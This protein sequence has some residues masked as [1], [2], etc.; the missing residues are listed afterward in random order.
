[1]DGA[2]KII[3]KIIED[4]R[5][6]AAYNIE[7][8][9]KEAEGIIKAA[10]QDV[11]QKQKIIH[12]RTQKEVAEKRKRL[13][14]AAELDARKIRLQAKQELISEV[15]AL[16]SNKVNSL[17]QEEYR[18]TLS[19]MII[20]LSP[21]GDEEIIVS[22]KDKQK[23]GHE[24]IKTVNVKLE[25]IKINGEI[26][27]SA[28]NREFGGGFILKSGNIESNNSFNSIIRMK[29]NEIEAEIIRVLFA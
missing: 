26:K 9:E 16:A 15:F 17:S 6:Q 14:A 7:K 2:E 22:N 25:N 12:E 1:M 8:A 18:N 11:L 27:Y 10:K 28:E 20:K 19:E 3:N 4:A 21:K 24:F 13:V 29:Y 5:L 23:L